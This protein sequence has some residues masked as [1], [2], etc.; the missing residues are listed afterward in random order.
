MVFLNLQSFFVCIIFQ[1]IVL[2]SIFIVPRII[3]WSSCCC[4]IAVKTTEGWCEI[5]SCAHESELN[6][7]ELLIRS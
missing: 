6:S 5:N 3:F 1:L 7:I 2:Q 4:E